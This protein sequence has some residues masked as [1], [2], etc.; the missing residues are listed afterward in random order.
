MSLET[1]HRDVTLLIAA[2]LLLLHNPHLAGQAT[3][4]VDI[5]G[6]DPDKGELTRVHGF[7]GDGR[8]G[9]PVA[10]PMD[11]DGDGY[12]DFA[13][14][15]MRASPLG[16]LGAGEVDLVFGRGAIGEIV[17]TSQP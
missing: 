3:V 15:Y 4:I 16:R 6:L 9:T 13:V 8:F 10:G 7:D 17:D 2:L 1:M 5:A 12:A 14:A 11:I